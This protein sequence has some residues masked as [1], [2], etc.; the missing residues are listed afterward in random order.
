MLPTSANTY[1][2]KE[3]RSGV[4]NTEMELTF[5]QTAECVYTKRLFYARFPVPHSLKKID[6]GKERPCFTKSLKWCCCFSVEERWKNIVHVHLLHKNLIW[7]K[8][9][10][11]LGY[12]C[13]SWNAL[14]R[15]LVHLRGIQELKDEKKGSIGFIW[16]LS[17]PTCPTGVFLKI[18]LCSYFAGWKKGSTF[19]D[20]RTNRKNWIHKCAKHKCIIQN[21]ILNES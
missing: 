19:E 15:L 2:E 18:V 5:K 8:G 3:C 7:Q 6:G 11:M 16:S 9:K 21:L 20:M 13:W 14:N 1:S 4:Y 10:C 12:I 17:C